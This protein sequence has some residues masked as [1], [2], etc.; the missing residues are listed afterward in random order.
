MVFCRLNITSSCNLACKHCHAENYHEK[1]K[2]MEPETMEYSIETLVDLLIESGKRELTLSIYG[3]EPL[4]NKRTLFKA[5]EKFGNSH[6][7]VNINWII[8]TNGTLLREIDM[9]ILKKFNVDIHVSLDGPKQVHDLSRIHKNGSPTFEKAIAGLELCSRHGLRRQINSYVTPNNIDHLRELVDIADKFGAGRIY[10]DWLYSPDTLMKPS[11]VVH[12]Y[13]KALKYAE[14]LDI[15]L[16]GPWKKVWSRYKNKDQIQLNSK[17]VL[18]S[19]EI[20][21]EGKFF[22]RLYP[23]TRKNPFRISRLKQIIKSEKANKFIGSCKKYFE[24]K[25]Q[26]C[27]LKD[28]CFGAAIMQYQYHTN[29]DSNSQSICTLTKMITKKLI[30]GNNEVFSPRTIQVNITYD[31]NR[32]CSYCYVKDFLNNGNSMHIKDFNNLLNWLEQNNIKAINL[33]GGEPT[34]HPQFAE[35]VNLAS[36]RGFSVNVFTNCLFDKTLLQTL[37]NVNGFLININ[38]EKYYTKEEYQKLKKNLKAIQHKKLTLMFCVNDELESCE[39]IIDACKKYRID[40]V[41][42]DVTHPN[43]LHTNEYV[44]KENLNEIKNKLIRFTKDL[45]LNFIRVELARPLPFCSFSD[46]E[47]KY[48]SF[49]H[50]FRSTCQPGSGIVSVNPDLRVN[51]CLSIFIKGPK[52]TDFKSSGDYVKYYKKSMDKLKWQRTLFQRCKT[53][54]H[55]EAKECQGSCLCRKTKGFNVYN[56]QR[57]TLYTQYTENKDFREMIENSIDKLDHFFGNLGNIEIFQFDNKEDLHLFANTYKYPEWVNGFASMDTYYQKGHIRSQNRLTHELCHIY[58]AKLSRNQLPSWFNEGLC[59]YLAFERLVNENLKRLM[60]KKNLVQFENMRGTY[61][62]SLL[63]FDNSHP[64]ENIAYQQSASLVAYITEH[65]GKASVLDI[66]TYQTNF[67]DIL[68]K[69]TG[70]KFKELVRNWKK[71]KLRMCASQK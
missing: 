65:F 58:I 44:Q 34:V 19:I 67:Y 15:N 60:N 17:S 49:G 59:E 2:F 42:I 54:T 47:I 27:F 36:S 32:N 33:T 70:Q 26:G 71:D 13:L 11:K 25:C 8:N 41:L 39:H 37:E 9:T 30:I 12:N 18:N 61:S 14:L 53:C 64:D 5:M 10:L 43:S 21:P 46:E 55:F 31:C 52:I 24:K 45:T 4:L 48:L 51:P 3:G 57:Y 1:P 23:M 29:E 22:F 7:G 69:T 66:L 40:N 50:N 63:E 35:M 38:E 20:L 68:E 16:N 56:R 62:K 6:K 28:Y